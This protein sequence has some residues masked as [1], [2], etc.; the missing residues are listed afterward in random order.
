M[1][2]EHDLVHGAEYDPA[3]VH[4]VLPGPFLLGPN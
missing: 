3:L 2:P 4:S 1:A